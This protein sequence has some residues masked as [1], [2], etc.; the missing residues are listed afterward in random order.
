MVTFSNK[1]ILWVFLIGFSLETVSGKRAHHEGKP[2]RRTS[3]YEHSKKFPKDEIDRRHV[4][5]APSSTKSSRHFCGTSTQRSTSPNDE[6]RFARLADDWSEKSQSQR[7]RRDASAGSAVYFTGSGDALQYQTSPEQSR[8]PRQEFSVALW[9]KPAGGQKNSAVIIGLLDT[10]RGTGNHWT[11]S[12][13][14]STDQE[15]PGQDA[16][17][18]MSVTTDRSPAASS[19]RSTS[20]YEEELWTH[21]A[22]S[23][24]G[25]HLSLYVN[26]AKVAVGVGTGG[27]MFSEVMLE[28]KELVIG[29][30]I[31]DE[32]GFRGA[33]DEITVWS[34]ARPHRQLRDSFSSSQMQSGVI[35]RENF[36]DDWSNWKTA[37]DSEP[38]FISSDIHSELHHLVA[39]IP[40]C[41]VTIC[42]DPHVAKSYI[43]QP[44]LRAHKTIRYRAITMAENDGANPII[45]TESI[46]RKHAMV[47]EAFSSHNISWELTD[48][49]VRNT[50]LRHR[51]VLVLCDINDIGDGRCDEECS[52]D[53]TGNDGGD[54]AEEAGGEPCLDEQIGNGVCD[55]VCNTGDNEFDGGD[56][57]NPTVA[58]VNMT[59]FDP[60]SLYRNYL[61]VGELKGTIAMESDS[62][63]NVYFV[64]FADP[65]IEGVATFPW[66]MDVH[67]QF[68]GTVLQGDTCKSE[69][70]SETF[71]HELGHNLGL[72]HV[73]QSM[74]CTDECREKTASDVLGDLVEDTNPT[75]ENEFCRDP[76][77]CDSDTCFGEVEF[78][79]TPYRN[80]MSYTDADCTDHFTEQQGARM[81][82][83]IDLTYQSWLLQEPVSIPSIGTPLSLRVVSERPHSTTLS[84]LPPVSEHGDSSQEGACLGCTE[85]GRLVQYASSARFYPASV[86]MYSWYPSPDE[87]TGPPD[88]GVKC[89]YS[90]NSWIPAGRKALCDDCY[91]E[92]GFKS[93]VAPYE[94]IL[95]SNYPDDTNTGVRN[96][97]LVYRDGSTESLG[98]L[99]IFCDMPFTMRLTH[100]SR[101]VLAIRVYP[102]QDFSLDAVQL[103]SVADW[104]GCAGCQILNYKV[105]RD[106]AFSD[107][108]NSRVVPT[109]VFTDDDVEDDVTYSYRI[110]AFQDEENGLLT[111]P[112]RHHH[113]QEFCGNGRRE[114]STGEEC[115]DGN[116][117]G[118]DGCSMDCKV[119]EFHEC[120][121]ESSI[122]SHVSTTSIK[123]LGL[124]SSSSIY[125]TPPGFE[126]QWVESAVANPMYQISKENP[127]SALVGP[128]SS[129]K[130][131][132]AVESSPGW[133]PL[134]LYDDSDKNY[135]VKVR[136]AKPVV[137]TA[138]IVHLAADGLRFGT[139]QL[140]LELIGTDG[141][142]HGRPFTDRPVTCQDNPVYFN[143]THDLNAPFAHTKEIRIRL[144]S[145]TVASI[146]AVRLRSRASFDPVSV[147]SCRPGQLFNPSTGQCVSYT[148]VWPE[149]EEL[150]ILHA[151][152]NCSGSREGDVCRVGCEE[153]YSTDGTQTEAEMLCVDGA[154]R[155]PEMICKAVDC[156]EPSLPYAEVVCSMGAF[157]KQCKLKCIPPAKMQGTV[158]TL[159]CMADGLYSLPEAFCQLQCDVPY[160]PNAMLMSQQCQTGSH[161]IGTVCKFRCDV[162]YH[163]PGQASKRRKPQKLRYKCTEDTTW[164]GPSCEPVACDPPPMIFNDLYTCTD[165]FNY[166]SE[167]HLGCDDVTG[168]VGLEVVNTIRCLQDPL[169]PSR[170]IWDGDFTLC[171]SFEG[172]CDPPEPSS[173][174]HVELRCDH[175]YSVGSYC[176]AICQDEYG[177]DKEPVLLAAN[178]SSPYLP[179]SD[180][181]KANHVIT[182]TDQRQWF[183]DPGRITC[184]EE[185]VERDIANGICQQ[186]NN[187]AYCNWDGGDCCRSTTSADYVITTRDDSDADNDSLCFDPQAQENQ[188]TNGSNRRNRL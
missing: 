15:Q 128:P 50:S 106:P 70:S 27:P 124:Q 168:D 66:E 58:D 175:G 145:D 40:Q 141:A 48:F 38:L 29:G 11:W 107:G 120:K 111:T 114:R 17:Y 156:G 75:P 134:D 79:E 151:V 104:S 42:D 139:S 136:F 49:V 33:V 181:T 143:I 57:C 176:T 34:E 109:T 47:N 90:P 182:C 178:S 59:C 101:K 19:V 4:Y 169:D 185:C 80:F 171:R 177:S 147:A 142:I 172:L 61:T 117:S 125:P 25:K 86:R 144:S 150:T 132:M 21:L 93:A 46:R 94:L 135:W 188:P 5:R 161:N 173:N 159:T 153:G 123:H 7:Q 170:G 24:D 158:Q 36:D 108:D 76:R 8:L 52:Y 100:I 69:S 149:C 6:F 74:E 31:N 73:H 68:G 30:S 98:P 64:N 118:G 54:C 2:A 186:I 65:T 91:L 140:S 116:T 44:E 105:L 126:D 22:A 14:I 131:G 72:W 41:G 133:Y 12:L 85:G 115:D 62:H 82:C 51:V 95:W 187:R 110:Q 162:G 10:C 97:E 23:Y 71:I 180:W 9:V 164:S 55:S 122:C 39:K 103:V 184:V 43:N 26:G 183:P 163:V 37:A 63:L 119:E 53:V 127:V 165:G 167:C 130:C 87:A 28:C 45:D 92:L 18:F 67:G 99:T 77:S 160:V 83:Y 35:L 3:G 174:T 138:V 166:N 112:L 20:R 78:K 155:G 84:W 179:D 13:G 96:L 102:T 157:G 88:A 56:C 60:S 113:G 152:V 148:C 137:A 154:W 16:R 146:S 81:H 121:G 129:P 1:S 89:A 32:N